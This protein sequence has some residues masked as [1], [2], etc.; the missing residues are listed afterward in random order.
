MMY[1]FAR[2]TLDTQTHELYCDG[3]LIPLQ[4]RVFQVL[5]YL[6]TQRHRL[7]PRHELLAQCWPQPGVHHSVVVRCIMAARQAIGDQQASV[8]S[9]LTFRGQGYRFVLDVVEEPAAVVEP[10]TVAG[11]AARSSAPPA[12][13]T[14]A[15]GALSALL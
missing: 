15:S 3:R 4:P 2:C 5:T 10:E 11:S 7:V 12:E 9:I 6:I 14:T 13:P 1:R 8:P